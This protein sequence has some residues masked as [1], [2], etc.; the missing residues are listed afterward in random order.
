MHIYPPPQH[1]HT[2]KGHIFGNE[3]PILQLMDPQAWCKMKV[4]HVEGLQQ[5]SPKQS[6]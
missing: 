6:A 2:H 4:D 5:I 3:N 1:T